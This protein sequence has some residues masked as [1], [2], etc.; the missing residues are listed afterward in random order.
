MSM[1]LFH[2]TLKLELRDSSF[3]MYGKAKYANSGPVAFT[4]KKKKQRGLWVLE[5]SRILTPYKYSNIM[6]NMSH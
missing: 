1:I 6:K 5:S 3:I 2:V 4:F